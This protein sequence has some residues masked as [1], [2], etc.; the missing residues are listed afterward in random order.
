MTIP[1]NVVRG[2]CLYLSDEPSKRGEECCPRKWE[3]PCDLYGTCHRDF[4][5]N[6]NNMPSCS[7]CL[8]H[9][10]RTRQED[11]PE[12]RRL[13]LVDKHCPGDAVVLS[14]ALQ[15]LHELRPKEF[16]TDVEC[17]AN[18]LYQYHPLVTRFDRSLPHEVIEMNYPLIN[19]SNQRPLHFM[20]AYCQYL[21]NVLGIDL[22]C[23]VNRPHLH[24]GPIETTWLSQVQERT[25]APTKYML[26]NAGHKEDYT[27]KWWGTHNYQAVVNHLLGRVLFVQVGADE[28][29]HPPLD[30]VLDLRGQ[31][32]PRQ[33]L[34]LVYHAAGGLGP[35]TFLQHLC[36]ALEK[37]YVLIA[38]GRE[39][40]A[41]QTYPRQTMFATLGR[42]DCCAAGACWK[43]RTVPLGDNNTEADAARCLRPLPVYDTFIPQCLMLIDP[44]HVASAVYELYNL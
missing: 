6:A 18:E 7:T 36:A 29:H 1:M 15:S 33:L 14:A 24:I 8:H 30:N 20:E 31:T 41:W 4:P 44:A 10:E 40:Q 2:P 26:V 39:P 43:S 37:P 16:I 38:G 22:P 23:V 27:A 11:V 35:S 5:D 28:H 19:Q 21:G 32:T 17:C 25:G 13:L 3:H 42:L 9:V 12:P 34:R